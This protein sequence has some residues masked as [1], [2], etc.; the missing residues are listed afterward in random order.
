MDNPATQTVL[1]LLNPSWRATWAT[2]AIVHFK[3]GKSP[4][5]LGLL[6]VHLLLAN[7]LLSGLACAQSPSSAKV[8]ASPEPVIKEVRIG[9][10]GLYKLGYWTPVEVDVA[11]GNSSQT[12]TLQL[13][14]PDND[15]VASRVT[16]DPVSLIP[17]R[18]TTVRMFAR[19][20]LADADLL[21][22]LIVEEQV[23][24]ERSWSPYDSSESGIPQAL[25][26]TDRLIVTVGPNLNIETALR[27]KLNNI[28]FAQLNGIENLPTRWFG[29]EGVNQLILVT[30]Q[31]DLY[32]GLE[33]NNR[34]AALLQWVRLG[35]KVLLT[36]GRSAPELFQPE[37]PLGTL[38]PGEFMELVEFEQLSQIEAYAN[39]S[40]RIRQENQDSL[41]QLAQFQHARGRIEARDELGDQTIPLVVRSAYALGEVTLV[42]FDLD[43][44]PFSTWSERGLLLA[45]LLDLPTTRPAGDS[46]QDN[47]YTITTLGYNDLSGQLR[48]ALFEFQ[49]VSFVSFFV[50]G[51][52]IFGYLLL[53]GPIDFLI[54]RRWLKRPELTWV[55][56]PVT[57]ILVSGLAYFA[58][59]QL[60][61]TTLRVNQVEL[62]DM[63]LTT[64]TV[65]GTVWSSLFSPAAESYNLALQA[66]LPTGMSTE[67]NVSAATQTK[68][69]EQPTETLLAWLG[70]PGEALGGMNR[71]GVATALGM[72]R[73]YDF[74]PALDRLIDLPIQVWATKSLISRWQTER[75]IPLSAN[76]R[77]DLDNLL[78]GEITNEL[79]VELKDARL[80][81]D[82]WVYQLPNFPDGTSLVMGR[83]VQ[84]VTSRTLLT[85]L[86]IIASK[87]VSAP[88]D[89]QS[90]DAARILEMMMFHQLTGGDQYTA[91]LGNQ[92]QGFV[93]L[94]SHLKLHQ[95]ILVARM[96]SVGSSLLRDGQPVTADPERDWVYYRFVIPVTPPGS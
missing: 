94:S 65:R 71:P 85:Q 24:A 76:L 83:D 3:K 77:E 95:A 16:S 5:W 75:Q 96:P 91:G 48:S 42:S 2:R 30:S 22:R 19:F 11:A 40:Q 9:F 55:T 63:D 36:A 38:A 68:Q 46:D 69:F 7:L 47:R 6:L 25:P 37:S 72:D 93:D 61:G 74:S 13:I 78:Q 35:G 88:Y 45:R 81:Y 66:K 79:G 70:L 67:A 34:S 28:H 58:A 43:R 12:A 44:P 26:A 92:Y 89:A 59:Y 4:G 10:A 31:A 62:I 90:K 33:Q 50:V 64:G 18:L 84:P 49:N 29:Y 15:G 86:R 80:Y 32:R 52:L 60:K 87:E 14:L 53:I 21:A 20:G 23:V 39:A 27:I 57:V 17:G 73:P 51:W 1:P 54:V 8:E 41:V 56:F 82:R